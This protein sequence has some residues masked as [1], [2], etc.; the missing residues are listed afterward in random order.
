LS[1]PPWAS[2]DPPTIFRADDACHIA[3]TATTP[4]SFYTGDLVEVFR[5]NVE[6]VKCRAELTGGPGVTE[7]TR[8]T[9]SVPG[10]AYKDVFFPNGKARERCV[11]VF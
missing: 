5:G 10:T 9:K 2:A 3:L 8:I 7:V 11:T 4:E 6:T 1:S